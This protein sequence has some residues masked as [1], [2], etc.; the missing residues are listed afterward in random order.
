MPA[1]A[2]AEYIWDAE[3]RKA[4]QPE[5]QLKP[6]QWAEMYRVLSPGQS[7]RPGPWRNSNAP[8]LRGIMDLCVAP[9]VEQLN[10]MKGGQLGVSEALRNLIGYWAHREPDPIGLALPNQSK[11]RNIVSNRIIP[12]LFD[13]KCLKE[14]LT[15]KTWDVKKE[16]IKLV[17]GFLFHLMWAG[18]PASTASD[19]MRRV[20]NDEVDKFQAWTGKEP[21]PVGRTWTRLR[22]FGDRK[23]QVNIST[24]TDRDGAIFKLHDQSAVQLEY[25]VPCPLCGHGQKLVFPQLKW[26]KI[27]GENQR[28]AAARIMADDCVWYECVECKGKIQPKQK[29]EMIRSGKWATLDGKIQDAEAIDIWPRGTRIGMHISALYCLWESW[30]SIVAQFIRAKSD[31]EATYNFQTETLGEVWEQQVDKIHGSIFSKKSQESNLA[32][33]IVPKWAVKLLATIDTQHDHFWLVIRAWGCGM[34]SQRVFHGRVE[35]FQELDNL[36][37]K[38]LWQ[39]EDNARPPMLPEMILIDSGGTRLEHEEDS[40]TVEVYKWTLSRRARVRAIKGAV[41][42]RAGGLSIWPGKGWIDSG[43]R[44]KRQNH[45]LRIWFVWT[46]HYYDQLATLITCGTKSDDDEPQAWLLNKRDDPE[47]NSHL[48]NNHKIVVKTKAGKMERRWVPV[49]AGAKIDL[50]D[51]EAYSIAAA[52][53]AQ[54]HL[55]PPEEELLKIQAARQQERSERANANKKRKQGAGWDIGGMENFL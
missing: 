10:L 54:I 33:G 45:D 16:Q 19:P 55:L 15:E 39:V 18:S 43:K 22:S 32:E 37:F 35:T 40:R 21:D 44:K 34:K 6:S 25:K 29:T 5:Q 8:Y 41:R 51:C 23:I 2:I 1:T 31:Y 53:M 50:A 17:N 13:T 48:S 49:E 11:G 27:K 52:Y 14:L 12:L 4:W 46:H 9:G 26:K 42:P 38:H 24:P 47:Y 30:A 36:C 28:D 20:V 3:E 7:D